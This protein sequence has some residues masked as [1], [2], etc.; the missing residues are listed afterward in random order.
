ML[1]VIAEAAGMT[2][3]AEPQPAAPAPK[4]AATP[5]AQLS[6][7]E[8]VIQTWKSD[9]KIRAEFRSISAYAGWREHE[10]CKAAGISIAELKAQQPDVSGYLAG[11]AQR[12]GSV[13][14][15]ENV[16]ITAYAATWRKSADIRAEFRSFDIFAS[17]MRTKDRG[18]ARILGRD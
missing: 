13:S 7:A 4:A 18:A 14:P 8:R 11:L 17:Y 16:A 9:A 5:P 3:T 12:V 1:A 2:E 15:S 6:F 10:E